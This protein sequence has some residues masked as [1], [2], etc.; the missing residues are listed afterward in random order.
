[1]GHSLV[2]WEKTGG[3]GGVVFLFRTR[4]SLE[5]FKM[6]GGRVKKEAE[7]R[8]ALIV[9]DEDLIRANSRRR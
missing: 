9:Q 3:F 7:E 1:M 2:I 6:L 8:D 5:A 4:G